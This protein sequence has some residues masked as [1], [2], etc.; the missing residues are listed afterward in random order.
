MFLRNFR[1][2]KN[3]LIKRSLGSITEGVMKLRISDK[4]GPGHY[5]ASRGSRKHSGIDIVV[6]GSQRIISPFEGVIK[7]IAYPYSDDLGWKGV[8]IVGTGDFKG[9]KIKM[10]YLT[11]NKKVGDKIRTGEV[12]G[13]AQD[14]NPRYKGIT[15]HVHLELYLSGIKVDPTPYFNSLND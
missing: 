11:I 15:P 8:E 7:R 1:K 13:H 9:V 3:E 10:F 6:F 4:F 12:I 2:I 14:L 5:G